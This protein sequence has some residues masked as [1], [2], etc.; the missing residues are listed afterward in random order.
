MQ[1]LFGGLG[2]RGGDLVDRWTSKLLHLG[3]SG[4]VLELECMHVALGLI[5]VLVQVHVWDL[6]YL[7]PEK[8]R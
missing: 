6:P 3:D 1:S 7:I 5:A 8:G 2:C 4:V